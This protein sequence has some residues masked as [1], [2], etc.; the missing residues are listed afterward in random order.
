MQLRR[1]RVCAHDVVYW[2]RLPV[3]I[4]IAQWLFP[5]WFIT[6]TIIEIGIMLCIIFITLFA[7]FA[8]AEDNVMFPNWHSMLRYRIQTT[9]VDFSSCLWKLTPNWNSFT[10]SWSC[11]GAAASDQLSGVRLQNSNIYH[12]PSKSKSPKTSPGKCYSMPSPNPFAVVHS[13]IRDGRMEFPPSSSNRIM[14]TLE[15]ILNRPK[16][17]TVRASGIISSLKT[18]FLPSREC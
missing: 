7:S 2:R 3:V 8:T 13:P 5:Y 11:A 4:V 16:H 18:M 14:P 10:Y 1:V 9:K 15:T 6:Y 17:V 12:V